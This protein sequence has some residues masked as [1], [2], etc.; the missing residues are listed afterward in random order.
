[1]I[2]IYL[3]KSG[4]DPN[5]VLVVVTEQDMIFFYLKVNLPVKNASSTSNFL[6]YYA[7]V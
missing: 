3:F 5:D 7:V 2:S 1:M 6:V 4:S